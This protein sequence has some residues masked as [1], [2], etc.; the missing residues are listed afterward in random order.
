MGGRADRFGRHRGRLAVGLVCTTAAVVSLNTTA[1]TISARGMADDL[2]LGLPELGWVTNAFLL[3]AASFALLGGRAG[4]VFGRSRTLA[5]GSATFT[6]GSLVAGLAPSFGVLLVGRVLQG[7]GA[8][9]VLP[10]GL[11]VVHA[12]VPPEGELV[13]F[14]W[15]GIAFATAFGLGPVVGGVATHTAGWRTVF[16]VEVAVMAAVSVA[17]GPL[18]H[19][20]HRGHRWTTDDLPGALLAVPLAGGSILLVER[21]AGWG[22]TWWPTG[23]LAGA[24]VLLAVAFVAVE[25]GRDHPLVHLSLLRRR[26][27]AG[28]NVAV[29]AA[30]IGM[31]GLLYWFNLF[32]RSAAVF[33]STALSIVVAVLPF[34]LSVIAFAHLSRWLRGRLGTTGPVLI[35]LAVTAGG[36][37]V[38][39]WQAPTASFRVLV[40]ALAACGI[41]AGVANAGLVAPAVLDLPAGRL[42]EAAGIT[43][44]SRFAGSALAVAIG[45]ASFLALNPAVAIERQVPEQLGLARAVVGA[46][47]YRRAAA[48]LDANLSA[49]LA[50]ATRAEAVDGF[51]RTLWSAAGIVLALTVL[52]TWLLLSGEASGGEADDPGRSAAPAGGGVD[53]HTGRGEHDRAR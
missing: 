47:A 9:L 26:R 6:V 31:V 4:D 25:R 5:L 15:R 24:V 30:S 48:D 43:T 21:A 36:F 28:A 16:L 49:A 39:A 52:A 22:A 13:A 46:E 18:R 45:T 38:L 50:E 53:L 11:E 20:H 44:L 51:S 14:R 27:L 10:A 41:G 29:L 19:A 1:V 32:A 35:G 12:L 37:A 34:T 40:A 23:A 17:C 3:T 8:A 2:D 33:D 7:L 42:D